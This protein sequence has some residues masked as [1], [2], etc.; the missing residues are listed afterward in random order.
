MAVPSNSTIDIKH[1]KTITALAEQGSLAGAAL[2]LNLTQSALS[3]QLKELETR[4]NLELYLRKS[5][6]LVLTTAGQ[7]LLNLARQVLPALA[8]TERQLQALHSGDAGR[9]HLALDCH[10]CIQWLLPLLP[11]FRRQWPGVALEVE[12]V[13]GFDAISSLLGGQLDLLL[14]SDVQARGDLHFEPLF[15]FDL[16]LVMAPDS[17]LCHKKQIE[18]MD[19]LSEVLL[20]YPVER[21]RMDVFGRFLQPAGIEPA[22]CKPV[23]NTSVMLQMAA[24]GLGVAALPN[25]ASEEFVR[26][27]LLEAR[28]L[29]QGVRR[30]MYGA[31]RAADKD[32]ACLQSLFERIRR[33][34]GP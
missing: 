8:Q 29:G 22:R 28:S 1:L 21:A 17:T 24:A 3:H 16:T 34:M 7:Q 5:R 18:P 19:L 13:P 10:S 30:H 32:Q 31:V 6:P 27:G 14:T 23:D 25:W 4:L 2:T 9:L 12:S 15:S 26:Q 11:D 33:K 20:V